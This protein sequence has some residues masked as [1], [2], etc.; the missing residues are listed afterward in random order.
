MNGS[1]QTGIFNDILSLAGYQQIQVGILQVEALAEMEIG[2]GAF[3]QVDTAAQVHLM[4]YQVFE[5]AFIAG[6]QQQ[7][8]QHIA[9]SL[10]G[11]AGKARWYIGNAIMYDP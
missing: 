4:P 9:D 10:R 1:K 11:R 8:H 5:A 3:E 6:L 2:E 7:W